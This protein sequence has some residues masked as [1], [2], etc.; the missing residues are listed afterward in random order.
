VA[1]YGLAGLNGRER[2][3]RLCGSSAGLLIAGWDACIECADRRTGRAGHAVTGSYRS[4][5]PEV[6]R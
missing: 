3:L 4:S 5:T 2:D 1:G 6:S